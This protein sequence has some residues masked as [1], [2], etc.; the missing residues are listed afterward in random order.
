MDEKLFP[1]LMPNINALS[2][3]LEFDNIHQN[4]GA[5]ITI[6]GFFASNCAMPYIYN[7]DDQ[8]KNIF[9]KNIR[10]EEHTSELQSP[11]HLVC[12][13]LLEKKKRYH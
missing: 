4:P 8:N 10:S 11:G 13:L 12:R 9:Y 1:D 7:F 5:A 6:E 3:R 2:P